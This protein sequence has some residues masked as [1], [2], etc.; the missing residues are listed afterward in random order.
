V[1]VWL[2]PAALVVIGVGGPMVVGG[3]VGVAGV[4]AAGGGGTGV[5]VAVC[6]AAVVAGAEVGGGAAGRACAN[7]DV[8]HANNANKVVIRIV[9][10]K[11][12]FGNITAIVRVKVLDCLYSVS[13]LTMRVAIRRMP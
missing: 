13:G 7:P 10:E 4:A 11:S 8:A 9:M 5:G 3:G 12:S 1:V 2:S 6:G